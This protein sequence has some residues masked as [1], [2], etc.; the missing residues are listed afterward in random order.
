MRL[1]RILSCVPILTTC[2]DAQGKPAVAPV[3]ARVEVPAPRDEVWKAWTTT[4]GLMTFL[5]PRARIELRPRGA[6]EIW[7]APESEEGLRGSEGCEVLSWIDGEML[8]FSWSA[9]PS[10][11]HLRAKE[12]F[13]VVRLSD[14]KDGHA[15]FVELVDGGYGDG[16]DDARIRAYFAK[17]WPLVLDNLRKRFESGPLFGKDQRAADPGPDQVWVIFLSLAHAETLTNPTDEEREILGQHVA[18]LR[19]LIDRHRVICAGPANQTGF[20][21]RGALTADLALPETI[22]LVLVRAHG[23]A[24]ARALLDSD[25]AVAAGVFRGRVRPLSVFHLR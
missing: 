11:G 3:V 5:A 18:H 22:G 4:D 24:D 12:H 23:E 10:L 8:S 25:P 1:L 9:P 20:A 13:V 7:F 16:E 2:L 21:P 17:A 15:T 19:D 6:F 14:S